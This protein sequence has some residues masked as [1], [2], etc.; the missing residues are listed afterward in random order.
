MQRKADN[1]D[2]AIA[3]GG[4][5]G[6]V[7]AVLLA[8]AGYRVGLVTL[9]PS[10]TRIEG[11]SPRVSAVLDANGLPLRGVALPSQRRVN[12]GSFQGDQNIEHIVQRDLFDQGLLTQA[13]HEGVIV[14]RGAISSVRPDAGRIC[15]Q[16][17][18]EMNAGLLFEARGRRAPRTADLSPDASDWKGPDTISIAGFISGEQ[19][20]A[21]SQFAGPGSQIHALR[22]GWVWHA[23]LEDGRRW[24]QVVGDAT[25]LKGDHFR[26]VKSANARITSL[27]HSVLGTAAIPLPDHAVTIASSLRLNRP[28]LDPR[29]PC[30]GDAAVALDPLSGHGLFWAVSSALM[31]APIARAIFDGTPDLARAFYRDRVV[32]TF[33]RQARVGRDFHKASGLDGP[34]WGPRRNWPDQEPSH[35]DIGTARLEPRVLCQNGVLVRGEVLVSNA[36]PGGVAYVFGQEIAP[37]IRAIGP[38][39]LPPLDEFQNK[40]AH[41]LSPPLVRDLHGWLT[42]RGLADS[43]AIYD[44]IP[45]E[46]NPTCDTRPAA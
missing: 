30:L 11:L 44:H 45:E 29:C 2:I 18:R 27:W 12:W 4:P 8:R 40:T 31:A 35:P 34:F 23:H 32:D 41:L 5:A 17:G 9:P 37:I 6:S 24:L 13:A 43:P 22:H 25:T 42:T 26:G 46:E 15:L 10:Q 28:A 21:L 1:L 36:D 20:L 19:P 39:P 16:D 7:A 33:W 3:G 38:Q 14:W